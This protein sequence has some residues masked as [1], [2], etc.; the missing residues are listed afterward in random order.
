MDQPVDIIVI[1]GGATGA[2]IALDAALRGLS[3][4]LFEQNDFAEGT[5]S[6]STKLV[7]GGVRYLEAAIKHIDKE[8]WRLVKEGLAERKIFLDNAPHLAHPIELIT[9]IYKWHDMLY[10]YAGL[11]LYDMLSGHKRLGKSRLLGPKETLRRSSAVNPAKLKGAVSYYDGAFNDAR[12][13]I[14]LLQSAAEVGAE[15]HNYSELT[16]FIKNDAGD[17]EGV[18]ITDKISN[19]KAIHHA[20]TVINAAGPFVDEIRRLDNPEASPLIEISSGIHIVLPPRFL[21]SA[22]G[23]MIPKTSDGRLLFA[24]PYGGYCMIGTTDKP[25]ALSDHPKV[26]EDEINFLLDHYNKYFSTKASRDD[27]LSVFSGLRPLVL[28]YKHDKTSDL[29]RESRYDLSPSGLLTVAGGK[30]TAYRAMAEK[31]VDMVI[32]KAGREK[33]VRACVTS[34][35]KV[36]GS[37]KPKDLIM[38]GLQRD[39]K[40]NDIADYLYSHYG[41]RAPDIARY[42]N[43][44]DDLLPLLDGLYVTKAEIRYTIKNEFVKKPLDFL[45]RRS[46]AA[47]LERQKGIDLIDIVA[48]TMAKELSWDEDTQKTMAKEAK[49]RLKTAT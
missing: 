33:T 28:G 41:D 18:E 46:N 21:P 16:R 20:K 17:I 23:V 38:K 7:H 5:S 37:R 47:L 39:K 15:V 14:A 2:G 49:L 31:A 6:R 45:V 36:V 8:Q 27:I 12:M 42:A 26:R 25:A 29:V 24:L 40:L 3:V 30:W 34:D 11:F 9:P 1:G 48:Q 13:V 22:Q 32:N 35:Y 4:K 10:I 44:A 43:S 19:T